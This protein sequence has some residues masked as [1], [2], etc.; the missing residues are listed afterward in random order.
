VE[1]QDF[2]HCDNGPAFTSSEFTR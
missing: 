1:L 2:V